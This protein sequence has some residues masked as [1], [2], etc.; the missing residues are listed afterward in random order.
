MYVDGQLLVRVQHSDDGT[1]A[2]TASASLASDHV[3]LFGPGE[4]GVP[5]ILAPRN[6]TDWDTTIDALGYTINSHAMIISPT[7]E[8]IVT[9][10]SMLA[11]HWSTSR[12]HAKARNVL[13]MAEKLWNLTYVFRAGRYF[14]RRLLRLTGLHD[15][16]DPRNQ[17]VVSLGA[18][19]H[20]DLLFC[21]WAI[22]CKLLQAGEAVSAPCYTALQRPT[23]RHYLFDASF[24]AVGGYCVERKVF[25]RYDL[26][27]ERLR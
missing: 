2:L 18:Q 21:K 22:N 5:P 8:K 4:A 17:N 25:W 7:R 26:P 16:R 23:I 24:H 19:F 10:K 13:S 3:R 9:I 12:R 1:T 15:Q 11:D 6:S 20:A 27:P 14:V